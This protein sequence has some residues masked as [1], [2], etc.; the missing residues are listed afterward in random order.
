MIVNPNRL[1]IF[2]VVLCLTWTMVPLLAEKPIKKEKAKASPVKARLIVKQAKYV[3][4]KEQQG[5]AFRKRIEAE[6]DGDKLPAAPKIDL[7]LELKNIS[8]EDVMIWPKGAIIYPDLTVKGPGVVEP[9]NLQSISVESSGGSVQP[10]IAPGKSH[11]VAI[12][13]LNPNGGTSWFYW[14]EPG[15]YTITATYTVYT[16]LP[17]FPFPDSKK[18]KDKPKIYEVTTPPVK[19][20]VVLIDEK[21]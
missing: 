16:G 2:L 5:K 18:P 21:E 17:P 4:P 6:T 1:I 15:E 9:E 8:K 11:R 10:N 12:D 14:S 20:K 19:V 13:S 3:L 7:V